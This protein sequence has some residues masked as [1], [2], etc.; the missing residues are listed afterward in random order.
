M[1]ESLLPVVAQLPGVD[2][3]S[4]MV[5]LFEANALRRKEYG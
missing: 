1:R 5:E 4:A 3:G 2:V